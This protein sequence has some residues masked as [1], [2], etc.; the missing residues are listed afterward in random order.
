MTVWL[1]LMAGCGHNAGASHASAM[2]DHSFTAFMQRAAPCTC[3]GSDLVP[4]RKS[5]DSYANSIHINE[6]TDSSTNYLQGF[7]S[8][9]QQRH[10]QVDRTNLQPVHC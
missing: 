6:C 4:S 2:Q 1:S 9:P 8:H 10:M 7:C 3:M 5:W